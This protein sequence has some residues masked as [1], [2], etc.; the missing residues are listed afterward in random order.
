MKASDAPVVNALIFALGHDQNPTVAERAASALHDIGGAAHNAVPAL[1]T[2][3]KHT[4]D[5]VRGNALD[6]LGAM[7]EYASDVVPD[8]VNK[9]LDQDFPVVRY[10]ALET[11]GALGT[12]AD[13]A[14]DGKL[15]AALERS[16][17]GSLVPLLDDKDSRLRSS[18]YYALGRILRWPVNALTSKLDDPEAEWRQTAART[19]ENI[20][21]RLS[22]SS[23]GSYSDSELEELIRTTR[24]CIS[25]ISGSGDIPDRTLP[26]S[27]QRTLETLSTEA[28]RRQSDRRMKRADAIGIASVVFGVGIVTLVGSMRVR[29]WLLVL[30]GRRWRFATAECDYTVTVRSF[31]SIIRVE[32]ESRVAAEPIQRAINLP[33]EH[34]PPH[35]ESIIAGIRP[36]SNLRV[37][38]DE[39]LFFRCW[40]QFF[41]G[42]WST[43]HAA[44]VAGQIAVITASQLRMTYPAKQLRVTIISC[45][46]PGRGL[47]PL[48]NVSIELFNIS[49]IFR[50]WGA[51][52]IEISS[53]VVA[54]FVEALKTSDIV[55]VAAHATLDGIELSDRMA[56]VSDLT[57]EVIAE[58][59]CRLLVLS[60]C[61]AG[62]MEPGSQSL[63]LELIRAGV[64]TLAAAAGVDSVVCKAFLEE[65]YGAMLPSRNA[66]G[67]T[68]ADAIRE[69]SARCDRRFS[70]FEYAD[71]TRTVNAFALFGDPTLHLI[72]RAGTGS[73]GK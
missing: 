46:D 37:Q 71:W 61:E 3:L 42:H 39:G 18:T 49:T 57:R 59:R 21:D 24:R 53:G 29:R 48:Q 50:R 1:Q 63:A 28:A 4:D 70:D 44:V 55:H 10:T 30:L 31:E 17:V 68:I 38:V 40:S 27:L 22:V 54:D 6:A 15:A 64:N 7:G 2:A 8:I 32:M 73:A 45:A 62:R 12:A 9:A 20:L 47:E 66:G 43:G 36:K 23:L 72:F 11:L 41:G 14:P 33:S 19:V 16:A 65:L 13:A 25:A 51:Q 60:A 35:F 56:T 34:W 69:S 67:R 26:A 52:V 5:G 58:V